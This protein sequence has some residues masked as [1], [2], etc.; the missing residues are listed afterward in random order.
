MALIYHIASAADSGEST[1]TV[2]HPAACTSEA[3]S[4]V[5]LGEPAG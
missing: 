2:Q 1:R 5:E 3:E 4:A